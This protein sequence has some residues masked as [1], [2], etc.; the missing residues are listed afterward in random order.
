MKSRHVILILSVAM[1]A[2]MIGAVSYR[3]LLQDQAAASKNNF[4]ASQK[5]LDDRVVGRQRPDFTLGNTNGEWVSASDFD[6]RVVLVNFWAT[7]CKPCR[8]EMPM[9]ASLSQRHVDQGLDIIGIAL[10]D[11]QAAK[12]FAEELGITYPIL[13]GSIDVMA[14]IRLYGNLS[15]VLPY[16]VLV[17]QQGVV[18]WVH[19]GK[20]EEQDLSE[21]ISQLL[22]PGSG[23][24]D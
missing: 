4:N 13:V 5:Q 21:R 24:K 7:W 12:D 16:S 22:R 11:V 1:L 17:D 20:L 10:D 18:N 23:T 8:E 9:L 14:V 15:G 6:G 2:S 19:L 3:L